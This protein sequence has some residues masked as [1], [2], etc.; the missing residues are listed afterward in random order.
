MVWH[1]PGRGKKGGA[2]KLPAFERPFD[3]AYR[4]TGVYRKGGCQEHIIRITIDHPQPCPGWY[5]F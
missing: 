5:Q 4:Q 3:F 2:R 1:G